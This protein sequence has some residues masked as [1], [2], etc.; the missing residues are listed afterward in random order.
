[1]FRLPGRQVSFAY[2]LPLE[3]VTSLQ[4]DGYSLWM[5]SRGA[6]RVAENT[7]HYDPAAA[8]IAELPVFGHA[9]CY[10]DVPAALE[11]PLA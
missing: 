1:M 8:G 5:F 9:A 7:Y 11:P 3:A 2:G 4:R 6:A 10:R